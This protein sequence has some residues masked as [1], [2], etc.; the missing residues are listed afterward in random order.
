MVQGEETTQN[1]PDMGRK[2]NWQYLLRGNARKD[3]VS[4]VDGNPACSRPR[5][6]VPGPRSRTGGARNFVG[7]DELF[8]RSHEAAGAPEI[9]WDTCARAAASAL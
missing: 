6:E 8:E 5:T 1:P 7:R 9:G 3:A 4:L 2:S